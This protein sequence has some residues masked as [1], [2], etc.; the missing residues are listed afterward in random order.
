MQLFHFDFLN[1]YWQKK[2]F[3]GTEQTCIC[4]VTWLFGHNIISECD[5]IFT[6]SVWKFL[7]SFKW[8]IF[9]K[10][11]CTWLKCSISLHFKWWICCLLSRREK[12]N[13][14]ITHFPENY[15]WLGKSNKISQRKVKFYLFMHYNIC[16]RTQLT[17]CLKTT[18]KIELRG[19]EVETLKKY[20]K[21]GY[22]VGLVLKPW[23]SAQVSGHHPRFWD[24]ARFRL[25]V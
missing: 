1:H 6:T 5:M 10:D 7:M 9:L 11:F 3:C 14:Y 24:R 15:F 2:Q 19:V 23:L 25:S 8:R 4:W 13:S 20:I 12:V 17:Q 21:E 22:L 16:Y 18:T